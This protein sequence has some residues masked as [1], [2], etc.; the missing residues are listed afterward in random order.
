MVE[1]RSL[2]G[3][4]LKRPSF[5]FYP[6]AWQSNAKLRR[7]SKALKGTWIDV[8]C[9]LHD[10]DE[11]G[12]LR[13]PLKEIANVSG[14]RLSDLEELH[15]KDVLKGAHA[16]ETCKPLVYTPHHAG[17]KGTPVV[18]IP[19]QEGPIWYSSRMVEDEYKRQNRA[20]KG[21]I[22]DPPTGEPMPPFGEENTQTDQSPS[23]A[24]ARVRVSSPSSSP[25]PEGNGDVHASSNSS[26]GGPAHSGSGS[27]DAPTMRGAMAKALRDE[28]VTG[29]TPSV[30]L[31]VEWVDKG[32]TAA[33]LLE[34]IALAREQKK[35]PE[36][37][38]IAYLKPIVERLHKGAMTRENPPALKGQ[39][40]HERI[41]K[42][43]RF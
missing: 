7:C 6:D 42:D 29:V 24:R 32:V 39:D 12:V 22:G 10:G 5:Q 38:P 31:V 35:P 34:A 14:S 19:E 17:R 23:R 8:L 13:W 16:G 4:L 37:I 33:T 11:Y 21:G 41:D 36:A 26:T 1:R 27:E 9:V 15:R 28:G 40:L 43:G 20:T 30:P 18:L 3:G 25:S 2:R